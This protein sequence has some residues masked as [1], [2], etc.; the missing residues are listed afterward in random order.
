MAA[1]LAARGTAE[2]CAWYQA[3]ESARGSSSGLGSEGFQ[4]KLL[5]MALADMRRAL[6][7]DGVPARRGRCVDRGALG[8]RLDSGFTMSWAG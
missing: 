2:S 6:H 3:D 4:W 7:E 8:L 1:G 5:S